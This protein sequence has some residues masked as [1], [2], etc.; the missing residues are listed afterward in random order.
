M[1]DGSPTSWIALAAV[2]GIGIINAIASGWQLFV[3][4]LD[5]KSERQS[6][7]ESVEKRL[8]DCEDDRADLRKRI[9]HLE[10]L[11]GVPKENPT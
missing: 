1:N 7:V 8:K 3:N 11:L 10:N 6:A 9:E 5:K 2:L 4:H